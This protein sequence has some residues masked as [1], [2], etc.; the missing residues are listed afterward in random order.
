MECRMKRG[1]IAAALAAS[2]AL[3]AAGADPTFGWRGDGTGRFPRATP[4]VEWSA[5]TNVVWKTALPTWSNASPIL[6]GERIFVC[7]EPAS[8]LCLN[9][10]DGKILWQ[11]ACPYDSVAPASPGAS[12][13]PW[14]DPPCSEQ[15][16]YTTPTPVSDGRRVYV[17]FGTGVA[18]CYDLS[19]ERVW[20]RLVERPTHTYGHS[21]SPVLAGDKLLLQIAG[22]LWAL[23]ASDGEGLWKTPSP[24]VFGTLIVVEVGGRPVAVTPLGDFIRVDDGV[25]IVSKAG[26]L[27]YGTPVLHKGMVFFPQNNAWGVPLPAA[28]QPAAADATRLFLAGGRKE[29]FYASSLVDEGLLYMVNQSSQLAIVDLA[30]GPALVDRKLDLGGGT[31]YPSITLGGRHVFVSSDTGVTI[32]L[33]PGR[34]GRQVARNTLEPFRS[35][36]VFEGSRMY[37]RALRHMYC[38]GK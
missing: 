36:P 9:K 11:R 7:A 14:K 2:T 22:N 18:A 17:L 30:G 6:V 19:G 23:R 20:G 35:S 16:G 38:I 32:V 34:E 33:E 21:S 26:N 10:A 13:R 31:T 5:Q 29:R 37:I 12:T 1:W 25:K 15:T 27:Q 24:P 8:L 3:T 4:V 28:A